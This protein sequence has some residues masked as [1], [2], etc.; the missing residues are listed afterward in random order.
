MPL[1]LQS[2]HPATT[3]DVTP[4]AAVV[5]PD[6]EDVQ[7]AADAQLAPIDPVRGWTHKHKTSEAWQQAQWR[8]RPR[9]QDWP[10]RMDLYLAAAYLRLS[11]FTIRRLCVKD[12]NGRA[13]L[14]HQRIGTSYRFRRADLDRLGAVASRDS[15]N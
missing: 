1:G 6:F 8:L 14:A 13:T 5:S 3:S 11:Y 4:V 7:A 9:E 12:R 10:D 2:R 15:P